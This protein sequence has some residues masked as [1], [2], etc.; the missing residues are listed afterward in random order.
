MHMR[1]GLPVT[2]NGLLKC[3]TFVRFTYVKVASVTGAGI[4]IDGDVA[5]IVNMRHVCRST[6]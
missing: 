3:M 4:E 2:G 5:Q 6:S 1:T